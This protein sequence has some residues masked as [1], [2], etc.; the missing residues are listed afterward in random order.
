MEIKNKLTVPRGEREGNNRG[1]KEKGC[2]VTCIKDP[3][4]KPNGVGLT[5]GCEAG[6]SRREW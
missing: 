1:K 6:W 2:Q 5:V 3:W 4:T